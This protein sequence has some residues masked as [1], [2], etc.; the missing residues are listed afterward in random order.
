MQRTR[1]FILA[2]LWMAC[3]TAQAQWQWLDKDGRKVFSDRPPPADIPVTSILKQPGKSA[4]KASAPSVSA[5]APQSGGSAPAPAADGLKLGTQDKEL[6][7]K[8]KKADAEALEKAKARTDAIAKA[9]ADN[10]EKAKANQALMDSGVRVAI[11][12]D[13]GERNVLDDAGR[14]AQVKRNRSL[15]E[16]NCN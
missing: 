10:C 2:A 11:T 14:A 6:M 16:A 15:I 8:K 9:K 4:L 13:K 7:D 3:L 12:D 1:L 5:S